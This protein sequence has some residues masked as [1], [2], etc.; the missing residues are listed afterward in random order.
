[1][2][3][4]WLDDENMTMS[5]L[6]EDLKGKVYI[7]DNYYTIEAP[8]PESDRFFAGFELYKNPMKRQ[9]NNFISNDPS[10]R[11]RIPVFCRNGLGIKYIFLDE[12]KNPYFEITFTPEQLQEMND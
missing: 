8:V 7:K 4:T 1:M 6:T 10:M 9:L 2:L 12:D 11:I 5:M 3:E